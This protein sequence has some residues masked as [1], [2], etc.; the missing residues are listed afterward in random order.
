MLIDGKKVTHFLDESKRELWGRYS[1]NFNNRK[2]NWS[3]FRNGNNVDLFLHNIS[4]DSISIEIGIDGYINTISLPPHNWNLNTI[5]TN[6][7]DFLIVCNGKEII[8]T[9]LQQ[10]TNIINQTVFLQK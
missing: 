8:K 10:D 7:G 1:Q 9:N 2:L 4:D 3:V 5:G 6:P